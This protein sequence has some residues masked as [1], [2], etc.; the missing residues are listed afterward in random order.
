M[1]DAAQMVALHR[2]ETARAIAAQMRHIAKIRRHIKAIRTTAQPTEIAK[3]FAI[4]REP[5]HALV[6][7]IFHHEKL[8]PRAV[9][10]D[11]HRSRQHT[12]AEDV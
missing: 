2:V 7:P 8:P 12:S 1:D 9:D 6:R 11:R 3:R 10:V 5:P 4:E